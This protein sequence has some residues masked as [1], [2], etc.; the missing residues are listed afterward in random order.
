[1]GTLD[2]ATL[3]GDTRM[4]QAPLMFPLALAL[5]ALTGCASTAAVHQS[6]AQR[7]AS[8]ARYEGPP[9]SEFTWLGHFYSW[10]VLGRDQLVV[11]T[12]PSDAYYLK[13]WSSCDLRFVM[14]RQGGQAIGITST[15][16]TVSSGLDSIIENSPSTGHM[17]CPISEIRRIDYRRMMADRR[18][19]ARAHT[20]AAAAG[21]GSK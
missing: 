1:M 2:A 13:V 17:H 5:A 10:E 8:Y 19:Q 21:G 7:A 4:R 11:F 14:N 3:A 20:Q 12:T 6:D 18:A 9:I 16:G 15:G